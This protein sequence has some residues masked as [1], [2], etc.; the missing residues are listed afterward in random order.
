MGRLLLRTAALLRV[1]YGRAAVLVAAA[2]VAVLFLHP[3]PDPKAPA[4]QPPSPVTLAPAPADG[5]PRTKVVGD[6]RDFGPG[7]PAAQ[8]N[9]AS[10]VAAA[11]TRAWARPDLPPKQ[12]WS[13]VAATSEE[14][15]AETLRTVDPTRVPAERVTGAP[16]ALRSRFDLAAFAV[17]TDSGTLE[18]T[19]TVVDGAWKVM[20]IDWRPA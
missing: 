17:P 10:R 6:V 20:N 19:L 4:P 7:A 8:T 14:V 18:V 9:E 5:L 11:F 1:R 3:W 16:R 15:F 13:G 2:V 12:W